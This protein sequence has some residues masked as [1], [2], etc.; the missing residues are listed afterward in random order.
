MAKGYTQIYGVDFHDTFSP[1][2]KITTVRCLLSVAAMSGWPL[3]QI[4]VT[5]AFLQGHLDEEIY[6]DLPQGFRSQ[7]E[8]H[9]GLRNKKEV[10]ST[11]V[12]KLL[13]SLYGL[14][15]AS[16]QWNLKFA[17]IMKD[18]DFYQS[19]HDHSMFIKKKQGFITILLVYVDDIVITGNHEDSIRAL[20]QHLHL[21]IKVKDLGT[22]RYFLGIEVARSKEGMVL[23]QRKYVLEL[24]SD[25]GLSGAKIYNTPMEQNERF[26]SKAFDDSA[27]QDAGIDPLLEDASAYR[28][29]V[30]RLIYL[31]VTRPD[32]CFAVQ[33]LSQFMNNPKT[34]HWRQH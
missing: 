24:I 23:N 7:G 33:K 22:L 17:S 4:D 31:T 30:G 16:R 11:K 6:M 32:I 15:Q 27:G 25:A 8:F 29:L 21:H 3:Y 9:E 2:A 26:T 13:K 19:K 28:R 34:S 1:V 20:K 12:C 18:A 14:K 10:G 5:N